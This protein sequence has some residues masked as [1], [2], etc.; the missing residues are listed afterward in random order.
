MTAICHPDEL[1]GR[2]VFF[3]GRGTAGAAA[4]GNYGYGGPVLPRRAPRPR[5]RPL[6]P[7]WRSSPNGRCTATR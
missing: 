7:S 6:R 4:G 5:R 3:A 1:H 2:L